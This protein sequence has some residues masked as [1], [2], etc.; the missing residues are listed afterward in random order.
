MSIHTITL[1]IVVILGLVCGN[2]VLANEVRVNA[3]MVEHY[4]SLHKA[5]VE[6]SEAKVLCEKVYSNRLNYASEIVGKA[7]VILANE[8]RLQGDI[9]QSLA[10]AQNGLKVKPLTTEVTVELLLHVMQGHH[11][12]NYYREVIRTAEEVLTKAG[13]QFNQYKVQA[14]AY[15]AMSHALLG[16][17]ED[18]LVD[19]HN[20]NQLFIEHKIYFSNAELLEVIA[21]AHY[22]LGDY[23][24]SVDLHSQAIKIKHDRNDFYS[25]ER[26][27]YNLARSYIELKR[28]DDAYNA[29]WNIKSFSKG[30][31]LSIWHAFASLGMGDIHLLQSENVKAFEQLTLAEG[32]FRSS[33][34][35]S[36]YVSNLI[37]LSQ[38]SLN[39]KRLDLA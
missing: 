30:N 21:N 31:P 8:S 24:D 17:H 27:Y 13:L 10:W 22:Y 7:T 19:L 36:P 38:S 34:L 12:K 35:V 32:M 5:D 20:A 23:Q 14:L 26:N 28:Y 2:N 11:D 37:A 25:I 1:N 9:N 6:Y 29:F 18:A 4:F 33:G 39:M 3:S 16:N 15:K